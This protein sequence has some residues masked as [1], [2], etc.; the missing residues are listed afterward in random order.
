[1]FSARSHMLSRQVMSRSIAV[2][3]S[4]SRYR[5]GSGLKVWRNDCLHWLLI[6]SKC[7]QA[8]ICLITSYDCCSDV[9]FIRAVKKHH[10]VH[11]ISHKSLWYGKGLDM[12]LDSWQKLAL[13]ISSHGRR[14]LWH[15]SYAILWCK[16]QGEC[17][18]QCDLCDNV[19]QWVNNIR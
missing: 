14:G 16:V 2:S 15:G 19:I 9:Y 4:H 10:A 17:Y 13:N 11:I 18:L 12:I 6:F 8:R 5:H 1:M 7:T 3:C